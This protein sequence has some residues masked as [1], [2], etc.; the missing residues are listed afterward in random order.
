MSQPAPQHT[1]SSPLERP[2]KILYIDA[3]DSFAN[4]IIG[5]L[6]THLHAH[7]T[8]LPIT[9]PSLTSLPTL[10]RTIRSYDAVV[11]GPGP[12]HPDIA[13]DVGCIPLLWELDSEDQIPVLGVCLGFQSLCLAYGAS[14]E[15]LKRARHGIVA[16]VIHRGGE[17]MGGGIFDGVGEGLEATMYHSLHVDLYR[18]KSVRRNGD[19]KEKDAEIGGEIFWE[20]TETCPELQPLA[21]DVTDVAANGPVL[22]AVRHKSRP[23]W[24]VQF[25]PESICTNEGGRKMVLNWWACAEK[26]LE[27]RGGRRMTREMKFR[28]DEGV[29]EKTVRFASSLL[30]GCSPGDSPTSN[31]PRSHLASLLRSANEDDGTTLRWRQYSLSPEITPTVLVEALGQRREEY[32]LLDSQNHPSGRYSILGLTVPDKTMRVTYKVSN[33]TLQY[34]FN[35]SNTRTMQIDSIDEVWPML[36]EALSL[37]DPRG[38]GMGSSRASSNRSSSSSIEL[39]HDADAELPAD[40]PFWG[41]FM[42]YISYEAGLETID[43]TPHA[44]SETIPDINFAFMHRSIVIDHKTSCVYIQSLLPED[45]TWITDT[46]RILDDLSNR[47]ELAAKDMSLASARD[48][49]ILDRSLRTAQIHRPSEPT[50]RDKVLRCQEYLATGDSYELC[51]TDSTAIHSPGIDDWTLYK[52]LRLNNKAPFG[53]F[54]RLSGVSIVGSSPERF[55]SWSRTG[56]CQFRPIKGTVK[57]SASVTREKAHEI[58]RSSKERAENLMIVDLIRHDLSGVI[59]AHRTW[60]SKLMVVEEYETVYQLVSV[61]EGQL[62]EDGTR[63]GLDVL[64]ASLPPGSMTGAPKKRSCEILGNIERRPRGIYSGVLGYMDVGGAGDFSVVIRTAVN[65]HVQSDVWHIGAGGAVT[66]QSTDEGEF[67]EMETK[68][69]SV[70]GALFSGTRG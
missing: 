33:K 35:K 16:R 54:L 9:S 15:R 11:V 59:G 65:S 56:A 34:G 36:Q 66:I 53:A 60:V 20:P 26:W 43:V 13:A 69:S 50:Y 29:G 23:F 41:G 28:E 51:L 44:Y 19:E 46:G 8:R 61:I 55:L 68:C 32:V 25:H 70:L 63:R 1:S 27:Q 57:K 38:R 30:D 10:K 4:N 6:T 5:L 2:P 42:G 64:R 48:N 47:T 21:W 40:S 49:E 58:L 12:G 67:Q 62:P 24:G 45:W 52:R 31:S 39:H 22:M 18:S 3:H 17:G 7:V 37:C 14:V